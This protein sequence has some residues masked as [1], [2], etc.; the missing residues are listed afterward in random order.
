M[1]KSPEQCIFDEM[2]RRIGAL[3]Y[4]VYNYRPPEEVAYPFVELSETQITNQAN[5][6]QI[7]GTVPVT[8]NIWGL[9]TKRKQ[10]SDMAQALF[11]EALR[12][13]SIESFDFRLNINASTT[14]MLK[15]STTNTPLWRAIV[16]L[17]FKFS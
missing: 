8:I 9:Y 17:E 6:S 4:D 14:R 10:V 15:D 13:R 3:G 2:Y 5:K 7:F 16:E 12:V 1:E 11:H